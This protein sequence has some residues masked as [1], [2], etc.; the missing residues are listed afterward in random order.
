MVL[1]SH[2][3]ESRSVACEERREIHKEPQPFL[4]LHVAHVKPSV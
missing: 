4:V 3:E 1:P 2:L